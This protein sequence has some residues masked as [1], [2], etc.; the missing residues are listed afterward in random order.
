[1]T[2]AYTKVREQFGRSIRTFQVVQHALAELAGLVAATGMAVDAAALVDD[3]F[4][5]ACAKTYASRSCERAAAIAH[6]LHG[7]IGLTRE[8]QLQL[9][10]RRL[11][12]WR[13][14]F[15][16]ETH[17]SSVLSDEI[18]RAGSDG[19]WRLISGSSV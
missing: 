16:A 5:I 6:Q 9:Y 19:A 15:G 12:S 3:R 2:L 18:V 7:A 14:E 4:A 11:W 10:T 13:T 1:M 17:W 8:H